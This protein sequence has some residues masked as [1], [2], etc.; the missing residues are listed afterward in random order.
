M[1]GIVSFGAYI[2]M[3]RL[4][5]AEICRAWEG[6][7]RDG[8]KA[9]ANFD[10]DSI[11]MAV[12]AGMES[13]QGLKREEIDSLYFASTTSPYKE[14]QAAALI[15]TAFDL[16]QNTFTAD[17]TNSIRAGSIALRAG[18]DA[19]KSGSARKAM[20]LVAD[21]RM[22]AP[23]SDL[24]NAFGD[25]AAA[26][27]L[28]EQNVVA[29]LEDTYSQK[30][31]IIDFWRSQ[32]DSFVKSW[33]DRFV[34][35][36]GYEQNIRQAL[37]NIMKKHNLTPKDFSK[38]AYYAPDARRYREMAV[39]VG[40]DLKTQGQ[41]P[42]FDTVGNTGAALAPLM[43]IA[44]L[45]EAKPG[46]RILFA[47]YGDGADA[48]ILKTTPEIGKLK[49]R[50]SLKKYLASKKP[51]GN[52]E[53]YIKMR[54]FM[55]VETGRK[56]PP[57]ASSAT[58]LWRDRKW[59]LSCCGS[60]CRHCGRLFFPPQRIC[61][62]CQTKD[63]FEWVRLAERKGTLF[64]FCRDELAQS[65]DPPV[66]ISIVNLEGKVRFYTQMTDRDPAEVK[67]DMPVELTF[68]KLHDGEGY[69]NYFWKCRPVR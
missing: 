5:R 57:L 22:G 25:G 44:A 68:R 8:E 30:D 66:V 12:A 34:Y 28:G 49:E 16:P 47:N 1:A 7:A 62:Y 35:T 67:L 11:T 15:S 23:G 51:L 4:S 42:L 31:D 17:F 52:Y 13:L 58:A 59:V 45:E 38:V 37:G 19:I 32:G 36:Q 64:T 60:Q 14:K 41:L 6:G 18:M 54:Q 61:Y 69:P 10:E 53:K 40:F 29:T 55:P 33:E 63:D 65:I 3:Y 9:V 24:E 2:P 43:L 46:D 50:Q 26:F 20:V 39:A 27:V 21:C 56:R 48:F